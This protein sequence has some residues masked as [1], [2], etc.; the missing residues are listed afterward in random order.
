MLSRILFELTRFFKLQSAVNNR[1]HFNTSLKGSL[2]LEGG[3]GGG[4]GL[5]TGCI[6]GCLQVNG[7]ITAGSYKWKFMIVYLHS[8]RSISS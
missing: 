1:I 4:A 8:S 7:L 5:K 3:G 6:F 2:Y